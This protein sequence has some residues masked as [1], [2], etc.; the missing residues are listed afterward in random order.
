M[1][2]QGP[3]TAFNEIDVK[4]VRERLRKMSDGQ[5]VEF[6]KAAAVMCS[7]KANFGRPPREAFVIQLKESTRRMA[8]TDPKTSG[9]EANAALQQQ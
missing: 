5:L 6:G 4:E 8:P 2:E 1:W 7:P 3:S 9:G